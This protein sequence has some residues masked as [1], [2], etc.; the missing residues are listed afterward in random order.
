MKLS[1]KIINLLFP[2][3]CP[4][5]ARVQ[6]SAGICVICEKELPWT[7]EAECRWEGT[8]GLRCAAPLWYEGCAREGILRLKFQGISAAAA[9][10]GTLM[11][12]CAAEE[13][14]GGF[15]AVTWVPVSRRRLR[16][17]GY[18]QAEL[19]ARETCLLWETE[20][21]QL[22]VKVV[23]TPPQSGMKD[24]AARRANVLG[25]YEAA[26]ETAGK[27]VLLIDDVCT[28]GA[29]LEE[30][31]RVL[32]DAEAECVVCVVAARVRVQKKDRKNAGE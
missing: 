18:D 14:S 7:T 22:L 25:A 30:C 11:A 17:R 29:T 9:P 16:R 31:A 4:F 27:R 28:T 13:F 8:G 6:D 21:R 15:D 23:D 19:L 10:I 12:H 20:P 32:R 3:K 24:A 5:C 2:P 1:E 26:E